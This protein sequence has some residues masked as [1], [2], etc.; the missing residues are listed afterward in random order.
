MGE[1]AAGGW[2]GEALG[3]RGD[4]V[5]EVG[6]AFFESESGAADHD[7]QPVRGGG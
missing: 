6:L 4:T 7:A 1:M 2:R 5:L 3:H